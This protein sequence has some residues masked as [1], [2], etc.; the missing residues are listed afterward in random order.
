MRIGTEKKGQVYLLIVLCAL[1]VLLGGYEIVQNFGHSSA[2]V[3]PPVVE[4]TRVNG[5][6]A[7]PSTVDQQAQLITNAGM[8]PTLHLEKLA[9]SEQVEYL[10]T[11][12][13]IFSADS[14]PVAIESPLKS[15][16][17]GQPGV[18]VPSAP[19]APPQP[20][21]I[22]LKYF[23]Y[24]LAKGEPLE[25]FFAYEGDIFI[26]RSGQIVDRR[27][28]VGTIRPANVEVTDL[29]Y[30]HTQILPLQEN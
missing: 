29:S 20:P 4:A 24:T 14:A 25:A 2:P 12:R 19:P 9:L 11:G 23:G 8:D 1:I 28:K 6:A 5:A 27:Y 30:N 7:S 3:R 26:A 21:S 17:P 22:G 13:N 18:S 16:R 15:A 10:G